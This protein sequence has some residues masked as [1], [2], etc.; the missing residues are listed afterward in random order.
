MIVEQVIVGPVV[1]EKAVKGNETGI[2]TFF[3][4]K[5]ATKIDVKIAFAQ[6]FGRNVKSV[7]LSSLP[8]KI[9]RGKKGGVSTKRQAKRKAYVRF[10]ED[11]PFELVM[12]KK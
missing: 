3:V 4:N 6:L 7:K 2:Y 10:T 1:T 8:K 12:L 11:T 9:G 5:N